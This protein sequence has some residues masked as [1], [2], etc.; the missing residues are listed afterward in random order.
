MAIL[1]IHHTALVVPD[2]EKALEFYCGVLGFEAVQVGP[3]EPSPTA[4]AITQLKQP[5]ATSRIVKTGWGYLEIWEFKNPVHPEPQDP[6]RP[7]NKY[8]IAH[9]SLMVDDCWAEYER[10]KDLVRFHAEPVSHSVEGPDNVAVTTYGR[11]PFGNIIEFW[12]IGK[13]DPQPFAPEVLPHTAAE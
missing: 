11:D 13:Q 3:I 2:L 4:E 1:G 7:C 5:E 10:L 8:G 12:Q 9:F 6:D